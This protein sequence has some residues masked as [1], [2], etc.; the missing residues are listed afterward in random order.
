MYAVDK[1]AVDEKFEVRSE[2]G[3]CEKMVEEPGYQ[4]YLT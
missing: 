1:V 2:K 4:S 3:I